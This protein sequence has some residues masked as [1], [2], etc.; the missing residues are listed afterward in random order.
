[1]AILSANGSKQQIVGQAELLPC[2]AAQILWKDRPQ[3][4]GL[5]VYIDNEAARFRLIKGTSPTLDS[6]WFINE[7]W[8]A[9][10]NNETT[11][12]VERVPSASNCSDGP[13]RR[14]FH[15]LSSRVL[16]VK[17]LIV[18]PEDEASLVSQWNNW[19]HEWISWHET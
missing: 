16:D 5:V 9:E 4:R 8:T 10:A 7:Y 13:S 12:R 14:R 3:N 17:R 11:T 18:P 6:A 19:N 2:H 15:V 1:M